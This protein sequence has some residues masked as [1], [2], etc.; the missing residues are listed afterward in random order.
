MSDDPPLVMTDYTYSI[1]IYVTHC[2]ITQCI[3]KQHEF[4]PT[5]NNIVHLI[6]GYVVFQICCSSSMILYVLGVLTLYMF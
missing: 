6:T 5:Y 2:P 1:Y 3:I 4:L